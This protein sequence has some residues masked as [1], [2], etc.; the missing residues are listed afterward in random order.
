MKPPFLIPIEQWVNPALRPPGAVET[1]YARVQYQLQGAPGRISPDPGFSIISV[2][3]GVTGSEGV[4]TH[5]L[6]FDLRPGLPL[7]TVAT[8]RIHASDGSQSRPL[9]FLR[10]TAGGVQITAP[11]IAGAQVSGPFPEPSSLGVLG[12]AVL[13]LLGRRRR[14]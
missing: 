5:A 11:N 6:F 14:R 8:Y 7:E 12:S 13:G 4:D 10:E 3:A 9:D 1:G 2:D